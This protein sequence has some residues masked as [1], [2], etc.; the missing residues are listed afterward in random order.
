[1]ASNYVGGRE[2]ALLAGRIRQ[3]NTVCEESTVF[4][5]TSIGKGNVMIDITLPKLVG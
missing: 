4:A 3:I 2:K 1:M 5:P